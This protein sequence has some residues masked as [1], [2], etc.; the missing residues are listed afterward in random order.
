MGIGDSWGLVQSHTGGQ[1]CFSGIQFRAREIT[2]C[3]TLMPGPGGGCEG[4]DGDRMGRNLPEQRG[5]L[6]L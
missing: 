6:R 1:T 2:I 4:T 5:G 3:M